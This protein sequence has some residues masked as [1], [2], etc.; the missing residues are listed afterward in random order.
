MGSTPNNPHV[1]DW[2]G[3]GALEVVLF[4]VLCFKWSVKKKQKQCAAKD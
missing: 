1:V 2:F 3:E 4:M